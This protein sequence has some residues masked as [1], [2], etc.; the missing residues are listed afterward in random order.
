MRLYLASHNLGLYADELLKLVG[1]G[2][3]ALFIEN[4]RDFLDAE[5]RTG[6]LSAKLD[7]LRKLGFEAEELDLR[8]YFGKPEELKNF[9]RQ[10]QPDLVYASGGN[11]FLLVT[12]YR[13][14]GFDNLLR[15][16]LAKDE[17]V[18]GGFSA[19]V[20][21]VC[22]TI[23]LYGHGLYVPE[24]VQGLYG[25]DAVLDGLGLIDYQIVPHA[26]VPELLEITKEYIKRYTE[27]GYEVLPLKQDAVIIVDAHGQRILGQ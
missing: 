27:A 10:Y 17:F 14:S 18:Y 1:E 8:R 25:V 16:A 15:D 11:V 7:M 20:M 19:G 23:K 12:A 5:K 2:R 24:K 9:I 21:S 6:D 3:K 26:D 4:A 13:L 22:K